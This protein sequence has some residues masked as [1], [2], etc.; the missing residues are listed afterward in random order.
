MKPPSR[1]AWM[2]E[3]PAV[4]PE[5][6]TAR[7]LYADTDAMGIVY[8]AS[9]LRYLELGRV[10]LLRAA[11][12]PYVRLESVGLGLPLTDLQ[13]HFE[14]PARYDETLV[15]RVGLVEATRVRVGFGYRVE[16]AGRAILVART[17]H[18][19][20]QRADAR[21]ARLPVDVWQLLHGLVV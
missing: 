8:H 14:S 20:V 4:V 18:C 10:E 9:Y 5:A 11:G 1:L 3:V 6:A 17:R 15:L 7:V 21:P 12:L 13:V 19:C 16:V 2:A